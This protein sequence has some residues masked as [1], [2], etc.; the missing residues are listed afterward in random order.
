VI[1]RALIAQPRVRLA[2]DLGG[3]LSGE[4]RLADAGLA[5]EQDDLAGAAPG[6]V[7]AVVQQGALGRPPDEVGDPAARRLEPAF[8]LGDA[9]D[10]EGF[11][12]LGKPLCCLP[13]E[14]AQPE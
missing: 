4:P 10:R 7:Q 11:D 6:L 2:R 14:V 9:R 8:R 3:E 13:S 12:R 1:G 5:R